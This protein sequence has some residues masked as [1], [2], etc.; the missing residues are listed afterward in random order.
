MGMD[1]QRNRFEPAS[2]QSVLSKIDTYTRE[3]QKTCPLAAARER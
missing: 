1:L 3:G 2:L